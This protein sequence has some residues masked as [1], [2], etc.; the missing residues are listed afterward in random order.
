MIDF[1]IRIQKSNLTKDAV[2]NTVTSESGR[3]TKTTVT[4]V[5]KDGGFPR[6]I[7]IKR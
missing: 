2:F 7:T 1:G 5:P 4:Y 6:T 3:S